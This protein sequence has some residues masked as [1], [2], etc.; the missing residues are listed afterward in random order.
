MDV[1]FFPVCDD[2]HCRAF[3]RVPLALLKQP[4]INITCADVKVAPYLVSFDSCR[5]LK[6][7]IFTFRCIRSLGSPLTSQIFPPR[8]DATTLPPRPE[9]KHSVVSFSPYSCPGQAS[10]VSHFLVLTALGELPAI[11][12][13]QRSLP[14]FRASCSQFLLE[15]PVRR[16]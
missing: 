6:L 8:N 16:P 11:I 7:F 4:Q 5:H 9:A 12:R 1:I 3:T 14:A 10:T 13:S 2:S 15:H